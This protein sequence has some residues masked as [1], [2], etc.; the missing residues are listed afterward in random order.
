MNGETV[1][2][3]FDFDFDPENGIRSVGI[4][5]VGGRMDGEIVAIG[6]DPSDGLIGVSYGQKGRPPRIA[7][8]PKGAWDQ[9]ITFLH[10]EIPE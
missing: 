1:N 10:A 3:K 8:I 6:M 4:H 7:Y 2:A 9:I 5:Y